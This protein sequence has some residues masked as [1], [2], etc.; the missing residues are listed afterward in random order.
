MGKHLRPGVRI[1][2][3]VAALAT[4]ALALAACSS[5]KESVSATTSASDSAASG[6][7]L[8]ASIDVTSIQPLTGA[9]A[10]AGIAANEG[11]KLAIKEINDQGFLGKSKI[12]V[13]YKDSTGVAQTSVS[14]L[15][16]VIAEKKDAAVFGSVASFE[17]VALSPI[18]EKAKMPIIYTQAGSD[19]ILLG[20]YT[21]RMTTPLT[22][23][24]PRLNPFLADKKVKTMAI[25]Y[26]AW[27]P[28]LVQLA[29][30]TLPAMASSGGY[31]ITDTVSTPQTITD[32]TAPVQRVVDG[33]PDVV[34]L[35]L[36]GAS[37]PAALAKL[38]D[39]GYTGAVLANSA[40]GSA[41]LKPAA[42]IAKGL[43]WSTDFNASQSG[44]ST[45]KFVKAFN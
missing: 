23:L 44:D 39:A 11:Y 5:S 12:D 13:D 36:G 20:D 31:K 3:G 10:F 22:E 33:K 19:G 45:A 25:I 6:P 27:N 34:A 18:A 37:Y 24:Y 41:N 30:K 35:E 7:G 1:V 29:T 28:T 21:F 26:G 8:P 15:T 43:T 17:A 38:H 16:S 9:V 14:M 42:A 32:F 4:A 2:A 40:M